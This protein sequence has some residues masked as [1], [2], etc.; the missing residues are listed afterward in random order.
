M[1]IAALVGSIAAFVCALTPLFGIP[2]VI[3]FGITAIVFAIL[4][5]RKNDG[6]ERKD[7]SIIALIIAIIAI[8][9]CALIN[10]FSYK[11]I[12]LYFDEFVNKEVVDYDNYY[13]QKFKD[14][15]EYSINDEARVGES[16][17]IK[18]NDVS[19]DGDK[20]YV[21]I[22]VESLKDSEYF[23]LYD[24]GLYNATNYDLKYCQYSGDEE[25]ISG[26]LDE[27]DSK[28]IVIKFDLEDEDNDKMY[29]VFIDSEDGIKI[30]L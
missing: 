25:F 29:L 27:G 7:A 11:F 2:F 3:V 28:N 22:D 23:S 10:I 21:N 5:M 15:K 17:I 24:L 20:Y 8:I 26:F 9:I 13:E 1:Y 12:A 6:K 30:K 4:G 19:I 16:F 14:Y 18:V